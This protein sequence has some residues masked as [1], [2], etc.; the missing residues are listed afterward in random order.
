MRRSS[1]GAIMARSSAQ[2]AGSTLTAVAA[3]LL[4]VAGCTSS[5]G[6]SSGSVSSGAVS[7]SSS[8]DTGAASSGPRSGPASRTAA[9]SL[10]A[11]TVGTADGQGL[12]IHVSNA[13]TGTSI[14]GFDRTTH[15]LVRTVELP[16]RYALPV[17]VPAGPAEG[18][19]RDGKLLVLAAVPAATARFA[20]IGTMLD[21]PARIVELPKTF[22]YDALSPDGSTLYLIEQ[23]APAGSLHYQV[24]SYDLN[25]RRLDDAVVVDK[26]NIN[27][28]MAG[29]PT[30][31]VTSA[32]GSMVATMY[33]RTGEA[34]FIHV[35][36][37]TDKS[38]RCIDLPVRARGLHLAGDGRVVTVQD[39][40]G[41]VR[42]TVDLATG[43]TSTPG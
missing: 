26:T 16:D 24:R 23:L 31:R 18:L 37:T 35:L 6:S 10:P 30:S 17:V 9:P 34:A 32:D 20:A 22:S 8:S 27:E 39:A 29:N 33:E 25:A 7:G 1:A 19:A 43:T 14:R 36:N 38:A 41:V 42:L 15:A 21:G 4:L 40:E 5:T 28:E 13:G 12:M 2:A 11:G 3:A